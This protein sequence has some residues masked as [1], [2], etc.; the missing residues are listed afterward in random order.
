MTD[1]ASIA[2]ALEASERQIE[3]R[4]AREGWSFD[5]AA[6]PSGH[7]YRDFIAEHL[8]PPIQRALGIAAPKLPAVVDTA[9]LKDHQRRRLDA[10]LAILHYLDDLALQGGTF[11]KAAGIFLAQQAADVLPPDIARLLPIA[12]ARPR[13]GAARISRATLFLWSAV[14]KKG[15]AALATKAAAE[16]PV[17]AWS[18]PLMQLY[19][20]PSKPN[21]SECL[22][23]WPSDE[24]KP[25]YDQARRFLKRLDAVTRNAGRLGP[26]ALKSL[27]AYIIR[28]VSNLWPGAV[29]VGDGHAFKAEVAHPIHGRPFR[30]EITAIIDVFTRRWVGWS[31]ALAEN[32]W[33]V[34]DALR[35]AVTTSTCCDIFY[36]DNGAGAKNATWDADVTG[37]IARLGIT[38][39]HSAP[40]SSQARGVVERFHSTVLHRV[41]R[42]LPTYTGQR[43]D[44]EARQAAFKLT[45]REIASQR[46]SKLLMPWTAFLDLIENARQAYNARPH[47]SL[48]RLVDPVSGRRR[49]ASPDEAWAAAV[50]AGWTAEPITAAEA[51]EL[52]RPAVTRI[53]N[54]GTVA[55]S[56]NVYF[57]AALEPLHGEEVTV[58]FDIHDAQLVQV[59]ARDGRF[60]CDAEW[61]ANARDYVPVAF[62][63]RARQQRIEGRLRRLDV[64][65]DE[66]IAEG[67]PNLK[68]QA[69]RAPEPAQLTPTQRARQAEI[70][71]ELAAPLAPAPDPE[72]EKL[73]R[74]RRALDLQALASTGAGLSETDAAWLKRYVQ[75]P[76]YHAKKNLHDDFGD[77]IFEA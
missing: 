52:F 54:R 47:S 24:P 7:K 49:H 46:P 17:P 6:R 23:A 58:A 61:N 41:A 29:F 62:A 25:S 34:A 20:R 26:R 1:V 13:G 30:P 31:A 22:D 15:P 44:K 21:L 55:L 73:A 32:T 35:H 59:R 65:R 51:R 12:N 70:E 69:F 57:H 77:A 37:M 64:H 40:W 14:A 11:A 18:A 48:S 43:M 53:V 63:E 19:G 33:S 9:D 68:L 66:A 27:K 75:T 76:E 67:A 3:R 45:R 71:A 74:F 4:A 10:R 2:A 50:T 60:V 36:Y 38:K 5:L 28:D 42:A 56:N 16:P 39:L 8:P 72:I